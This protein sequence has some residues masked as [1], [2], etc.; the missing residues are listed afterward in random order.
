MLYQLRVALLASLTVACG[1]IAASANTISFQGLYFSLT[2]LGGG[3]LEVTISPVNG[4]SI[5]GSAMWG[6]PIHYLANLALKPSGGT[7]TGATLSGWTPQAGGMNANGCNGS[8]AGWE[9]FDSNPPD[10][11][12]AT[13]NM[14]FDVFFTGGTVDFS[15]TALKV[16]FYQYV[17]QTKNTGSLLSQD[18]RVA[19]PVPSPVL[20]AGVPGMVIAGGLLGWWG[21]RKRKK[22]EPALRALR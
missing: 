20:G 11:I 5:T 9:C 4:N 12:P 16:E 14:V 13:G 7:Y 21:R 19:A 8:G 3:E 17:N 18:I 22:V 15:T 10:S 6:A 1:S 2:N